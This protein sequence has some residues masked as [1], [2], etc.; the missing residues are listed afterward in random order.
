M[1]AALIQSLKPLDRDG[2][3]T[4]LRQDFFRVLH[5]DGLRS[6]DPRLAAMFE[7]LAN[8]NEA[9]PL[10]A[11]LEIAA[12]GGQTVLSALTG[13]MAVPDFATFRVECKRIFDECTLDLGL[14]A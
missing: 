3:G 9:I 5:D 7:A 12:L 1:R 11:L 6:D 14:I 13:K 4:V 8:E 10:P 2:T